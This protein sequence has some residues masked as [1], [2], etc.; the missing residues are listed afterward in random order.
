MKKVND[1]GEGRVYAFVG[2][3]GG[4]KS[5]RL[6]ITRKTAYAQNRPFLAGDFSDG[7]C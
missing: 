4:G 3:S 1:V 7:M 6:D 2:P 5:Y